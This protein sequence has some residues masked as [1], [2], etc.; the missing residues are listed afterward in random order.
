VAQAKKIVADILGREKRILAEPQAAVVVGEL[1]ESSVNLF[2]RP[3]IR[4]GDYWDVKWDLL[5][6]IKTEFDRQGI[7]IPFP[8]QEVTF[9]PA[10][11]VALPKS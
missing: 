11:P 5:E 4:T 8:Q 10:S 7:T 3:W 9:K 1:A 6:A 2:V